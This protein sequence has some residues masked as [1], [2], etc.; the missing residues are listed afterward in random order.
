MATLNLG[1]VR[2]DFRGDYT[3][4]NGQ[5]LVFFDAVTFAG[6]LYVVKVAEVVVDDSAT[7]NR[8]PTANG[9]NSFLKITEGVEF[10]GRWD[11]DGQGTSNR[12]YFQNQLVQYGPNT[13]IALQEIAIGSENPYIEWV[14][15]TGTWAIISKGFGNYIPN[16][17]GSQTL[18]PGDLINWNG[19]I[20]L[21]IV[22]VDVNQT[23]TSHPDYYDRLDTRLDPQG[24]WQVGTAYE[25]SDAVVYYGSTYVVTSN[26]PTTTRPVDTAT[27]QV[28]QNWELLTEGIVYS[29]DFDNRSIGYFKNEIIR[30]NDATYIVLEKTYF[31]QNPANT[32]FKFQLI[33]P[34]DALRVSDFTEDGFIKRFN[35]QL[36]IDTNTYLQENENITIT[37]EATGSGNTEIPL[38]LTVS[39]VTNQSLAA[40]NEITETN[41]RLFGAIDTGNGNY[42]LRQFD[43]NT[44]HP[45]LFT[46]FDDTEGIFRIPNEEG[47][48]V[49]LGVNDKIIANL[50]AVTETSSN[51]ADIDA[52]DK[53][54]FRKET[55]QSLLSISYQQLL[56]KLNTQIIG[57][58]VD[59]VTNFRAL[60]DTPSTYTGFEG[61]YVRIND[62][63]NALEFSEDD[64]MLQVLIYG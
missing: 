47:P 34:G 4:L 32:A 5:T 23:P 53:F 24:E 7:G 54:M 3:S 55:T 8:P 19:S 50:S 46:T 26:N 10:T 56:E 15:D 41:T 33:V 49:T 1:R 11:N 59:G 25:T 57:N 29:G 62:A 22:N 48:T 37:G 40:A 17:D 64:I 28:N 63:G 43:P 9:Q 35:G 13:F 52:A 36:I 60:I 39:A 12:I 61:G 16:Y 42:E 21:A 38:T 44:I 51:V 45:D 30:Y 18:D 6:S 2:I 14:N 58:Q 20:W 31:G 27:G